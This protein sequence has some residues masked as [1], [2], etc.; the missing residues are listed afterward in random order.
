MDARDDKSEQW[1]QLLEKIQDIKFTMLT[2]ENEE[3]V[4]H[5]R[6]MAT[7]NTLEEGSLWFFTGKSTHK[8]REIGRHPRVNLAFVAGGKDTFVS[9]AGEAQL[10]E[11]ASK[12]EE[13][14]N[15]MMQ[16][17]F[18]EG[19]DDPELILLRVDVEEAEYWDVASRKM[20][21]FTQF[22]KS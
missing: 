4:L 9:I 2:T 18:P 21:R 11:D 7:L 10:V 12:A 6:P 13:L 16:A 15:P 14:W 5:S 22:A 3:G 8:C 19:L 20:T 1:S 17:W